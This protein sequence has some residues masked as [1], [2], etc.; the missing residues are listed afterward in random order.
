MG[1]N[2]GTILIVA[3][4]IVVLFI[5]AVK[6][7]MEWMIDIVMRSIWGTLAIHF[8]NQILANVGISLG[9]GI[10]VL[11]ILTSGILGIPG[12]LALYGIGILQLL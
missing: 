10:N 8:I 7:K 11:T 5:G 9:V 3:V 4:C 2:L 1:E 6:S 12:L